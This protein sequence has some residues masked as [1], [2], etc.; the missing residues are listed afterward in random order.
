MTTSGIYTLT[1]QR[2]DIIRQAMLNLGKL[3]EGEN[4]TPQEIT[5]M[6]LKLNMLVKQ[7]MG[8]ADFAPGLKTWTRRRGNLFLHNNTGK[9]TVGPNATGW[10][11]SFTQLT[12]I[13]ASAAGTNTISVAAGTTGITNGD[14][15]GVQ[16]TTGGGNGDIQ[17]TTVSNYNSGTGV[18]TLG[19][20]LTAAVDIG[21]TAYDYT[22]TAQNPLTIES[23]VLRDS[24]NSNEDTPV[25]IMASTQDYDM[26][27]SKVDLNNISDPT[28]IYYEWQLTN[29]F[30]F[31]DVAAAQDV[32]K[33]LVLTF[34]EE[35]QTFVNPTDNP[36]YP[37]EWFDPLCWGLSK[38]SAPMFNLPW[39][40]SMEAIYQECLAIAK[41]KGP[42]KSSLF[43]Q[44]G[45]DE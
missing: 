25:K 33:Y 13:A 43:F 3:G 11:T 45:E 31:T 17:W 39:T 2:D 32:T 44:P 30:L 40:Q 34:L 8:K 28:Q 36:E 21:A 16:I 6:A 20:N 27:P 22:T 12:T 10:T 38:R 23:A 26:L 4:P 14:N 15:I 37:A 5:D 19:A 29:S 24:S 35:I 1:V 42:E 18:I 41:H 7:W 9:Y